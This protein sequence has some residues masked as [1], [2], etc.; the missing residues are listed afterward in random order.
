MT[1]TRKGEYVIVEMSRQK[2]ANR[3]EQHGYGWEGTKWQMYNAEHVGIYDKSWGKLE[4]G[5]IVVFNIPNK[6]RYR[7]WG[8]G[9]RMNK[10]DIQGYS[11][12]GKSIEKTV[13]E[14]AGKATP[15]SPE[16]SK[17]L[18]KK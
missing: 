18:L 6:V 3:V 17:H 7:G 10:G 15:L 11:W 12:N 16:E 5:E 14:I 9:H 1:E 8:F 2:L 4:S 13:F